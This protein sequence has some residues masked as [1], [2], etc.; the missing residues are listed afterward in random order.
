[1]GNEN[2][3]S[4]RTSLGSLSLILSL[5][6]SGIE[7]EWPLPIV[8]NEMG[9]VID[10]SPHTMM[11]QHRICHHLWSMSFAHFHFRSIFIFSLLFLF[12][13][14]PCHYSF[15]Q[16]SLINDFKQAGMEHINFVLFFGKE[17]FDNKTECDPYIVTS[18]QINEYFS[19]RTENNF[20]FKMKIGRLLSY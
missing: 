4:F 10:Q 1:M 18:N 2:E 9:Q 13:L 3:L 11:N 8:E 12:W 16:I 7:S 19:C 5:R 20:I 6:L 17:F 14:S 15:Y